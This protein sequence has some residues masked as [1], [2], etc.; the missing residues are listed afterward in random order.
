MQQLSGTDPVYAVQTFGSAPQLVQ[1][2]ANGR[3]RSFQI[4][5]YAEVP[6]IA[7]IYNFTITLKCDGTMEVLGENL[8]PDL[9]CTPG[10][11]IIF[12]TG[13]PASTYSVSETD[14]DIVLVNVTDYAPGGGC[15]D[16]LAYQVELRFTEH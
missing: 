1:I 11:S 9:G 14:D 8:G 4:D 2:A 6:S 7:K 3:Q 12:S 10:I 13:I 5:Y 16:E 15:P